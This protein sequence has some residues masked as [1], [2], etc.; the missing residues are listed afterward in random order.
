MLSETQ[1]DAAVEWWGKAFE[2]PKFQ[3]L[4]PDDSS[5]GSR[6]AGMA[7]LM[8]TAAHETPTADSIVKFKDALREKLQLGEVRLSVDYGPSLELAKCLEAA[9]GGKGISSLPWKT[10]MRFDGEGV[11]VACG[12]GE[13]FLE[14]VN[15]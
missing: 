6:P 1:I 9:G 8:A 10:S 11:Q 2:N 12:Y 5:E 15:A 14:L 3:T 13:P 7:Q 4:R